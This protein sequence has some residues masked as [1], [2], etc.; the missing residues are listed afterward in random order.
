VV[1]HRAHTR[2]EASARAKTGFTIIQ[3]ALDGFWVLAEL[4]WFT[5]TRTK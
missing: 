4:S 3:G 5:R 2:L 1:A